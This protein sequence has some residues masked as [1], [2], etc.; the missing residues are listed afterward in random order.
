MN[1]NQSKKSVGSGALFL[2]LAIFLTHCSGNPFASNTPL[3]ARKTLV[4]SKQAT[5]AEDGLWRPAP[6]NDIPVVMN[7]D[8]QRWVELF[9]GRFKE[10]FDRWTARLGIY[11][12]TIEKILSEED[13]PSDLIYLAMIESGFNLSATSSAACVG[14]WQFSRDTGR[15]YG[16]QNDFF[17]DDRRDLVVA[18]HAAARHLHDLY[19]T[20]GDWYLAF[21]A[22]NAGPGKVNK[23]IQHTGSKNYWTL[24]RSRYLRQETKDYVPKILAALHIVKNYRKYG[25]SEA[26]F[27][28]PMQYDRVVIPDA[29][30]VAVIA[31]SSNA[32]IDVI[33]ELNPQL[34]SGITR[35]GHAVP[36]NI[37][38]GSE[39]LFNRQYALIP[40][41]ERVSGLFHKVEDRDTLNSIAKLYGVK[42][43][44]IAKLNK[45]S[46]NEHLAPGQVVRIPADHKVLFAMANRTTQRSAGGAWTTYKIRR[47]DTVNSIAKRYHTS[48]RN[49]L[50]WNHLGTR[51]HLRV[52]QKLKIHQPGQGAGANSLYAIMPT[53]AVP[54]GDR[55][56][57][58]AHIIAEDELS[59][60]ALG[61]TNQ[62]SSKGEINNEV[63]PKMVAVSG[64]FEPSDAE[65]PSI[66]RT[67]D[68]DDKA[69][70]A[71]I[72]SQTK[73][74]LAES[75]SDLN[76]KDHM[77]VHQARS[78][79]TL[80][81][82]SQRYGVKISDIKKWNNLRSDT[83]KPN[84]KIRILAT[85][86]SKRIALVKS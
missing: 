57:G 42:K 79:D 46:L 25:Y 27:G 60:V 1:L 29:T 64:G 41:D 85:T 58:V 14:A 61:F 16:L 77:I 65:Q 67:I 39:D 81:K 2:C 20:Y 33:R 76:N 69:M 5:L 8:V 72:E 7:P 52:G 45:F 56:S 21:A 17:M 38:K 84:Q 50:T 51:A 9:Q 31:K 54:G 23:A 78:G 12:P 73:K 53:L 37:P 22:Y 40:T 18:T 28:A 80:W 32:S 63:L 83:L 75:K 11:G 6:Q 15:M 68:E 74:I 3:R 36:V 4:A 47:G 55:M 35:P 43:E 62:E 24:A 44:H 48:V 34:T 71:A 26:S 19:K 13:V 66:I 70:A 49:V 59:P 30:D 82:I 10:N 86:N